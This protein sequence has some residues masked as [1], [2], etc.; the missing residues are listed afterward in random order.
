LVALYAVALF[1]SAFLMFSVEPMIAKMVLPILGGAPMVWNTCVVFFQM[2]LLG[3]YGVAYLATERLRPGLYAGVYA[4][5]LIVSLFTLPLRLR[6]FG[7]PPL[8]SIPVAWLLAVLAASMGLPFLAL[9]TST[10]MLQKMLAATDIREA[11]D[12]YSLY[13]ASNAGGLVALLL[14]PTVVE[15]LLRLSTQRRL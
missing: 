4:G 5:L 2:A 7:G 6:L 12:P 1:L 14:Y 3:G 11:R 9:S 13:A 10:S 8:D 15:P